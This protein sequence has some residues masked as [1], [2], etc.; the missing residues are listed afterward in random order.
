[1][2]PTNPPGGG[3]IKSGRS[4]NAKIID[5]LGV[6]TISWTKNSPGKPGRFKISED[7]SQFDRLPE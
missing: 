6:R 5:P 7:S 2:S 1:M 3:R 4:V